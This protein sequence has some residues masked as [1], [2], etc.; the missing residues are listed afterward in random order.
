MDTIGTGK[1]IVCLDGQC[2]DA[3][4]EKKNKYSRTRYYNEDGSE[5]KFNAGSAWIEIVNENI[6]VSY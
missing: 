1:A 4:W 3:S 5:V 6:E 2:L